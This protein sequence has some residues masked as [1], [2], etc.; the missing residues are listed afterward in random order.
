MQ[1]SNLPASGSFS[2]TDVLAI[3]VNGITYRL[4]GATLAAAL[5]T[6]GN[7]V[8]ASDYP[9]TVAH[10]GTGAS[11]AAAARSNLGLGNVD[12]TSDADKPVSTAQAAALAAQR[13]HYDNALAKIGLTVYNDQFYI[14]PYEGEEEE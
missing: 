3:E 2:G 11:N 5:K 13:A 6:I 4:T 8:S 12:N 7:Y 9:I 14:Q 1:I 10:G